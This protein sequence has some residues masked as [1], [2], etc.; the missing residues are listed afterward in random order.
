MTEPIYD[1]D[2]GTLVLG[3][4]ELRAL[5]IAYLSGVATAREECGEQVVDRVARAGCTVDGVVDEELVGILDT[6]TRPCFDLAVA[7]VSV[8]EPVACCGW[9]SRHTIVVARALGDGRL[10][11]DA[12]AAIDTPVLLGR[13]VDL[14]PRPRSEATPSRVAA[15]D[16]RAWLERGGEAPTSLAVGQTCRAWTIAMS[17]PGTDDLVRQVTVVDR[18]EVGYYVVEESE[19]GAEHIVVLVPSTSA[20]VFGLLTGFLQDLYREP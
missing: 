11:L 19:E 12:G 9:L 16:L 2:S 5:G 14:G 6:L 17:E 8:A 4:D 7:A 18:E 13:L 1:P 3:E 15:E 20:S 10:A